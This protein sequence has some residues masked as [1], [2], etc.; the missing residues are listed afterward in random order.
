MLACM[1]TIHTNSDTFLHHDN[2]FP[3]TMTRFSTLNAVLSLSLSRFLSV[4]GKAHARARSPNTAFL[5]M[6]PSSA[7][8]AEIGTR[9]SGDAC[10]KAG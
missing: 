4:R 7:W 8:R 5:P 6:L 10:Q 2:R 9:F 3:N 1:N